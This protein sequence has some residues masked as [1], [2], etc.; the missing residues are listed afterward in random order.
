MGN[1]SAEGWGEGMQFGLC[2]PSFA[3]RGGIH[4]PLGHVPSFGVRFGLGDGIGAVDGG[5]W[6]SVVWSVVHNVFGGDRALHFTRG[7]GFIDSRIGR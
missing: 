2:I 7:W 5:W 3:Q 6:A 4:A 1:R